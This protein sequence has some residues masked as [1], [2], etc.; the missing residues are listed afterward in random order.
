MIC[1]CD[2]FWQS[3][4]IHWFSFDSNYGI[5]LQQLCGIL[6]FVGKLRGH[7]GLKLNKDQRH[8]IYLSEEIINV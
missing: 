6:H 7:E 4:P 1:Y 3:P 5:V 8:Y 2:V